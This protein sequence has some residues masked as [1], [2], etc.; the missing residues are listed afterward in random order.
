MEST[1]SLS[2][3]DA[4]VES[5]KQKKRKYLLL[6]G[7][8]IIFISIFVSLALASVLS[9]V[10]SNPIYYTFLKIITVLS[11][12]LIAI[13][14]LAIPVLRETGTRGVLGELDKIAPG[15]G[16]DTL[17]ALYL[18]NN[19]IQN[20]RILG[21]S[22]ILALAHIDNTTNKLGALDHTVLFPIS[23][24]KRYLI[25]LI[26]GAIFALIVLIFFP[27][28][29]TSY[30]LS[31]NV[32]P[33]NAG[34]H[35]ELGDIEI[36][37]K[38]PEYTKLSTQKIKGSG[39]EVKAIKGTEV[40]FEAKPL[41]YFEK[42]S[43]IVENGVSV[44]VSK[45]GGKIKAGFTV[46]GSASFIIKETSKALISETFEIKTEEDTE[47]GVSI[48]SPSGETIELGSEEKIDIFFEAQDDYGISKL[49]LTWEN[50]RGQSETPISKEEKET[51]AISD[52]LSWGPG[53]INPGDGDTIKLRVIAYDNDTV[54]G[55]KVGISNAIT[56]ILKDARS[57]HKETLIYAEQL[58]EELI[59]ILGDEIN[60]S[61]DGASAKST[62]SAGNSK[63]GPKIID[64]GEVLKIQKKLTQKIEHAIQT[65]DITIAN[66]KEDEYS[67]FTYF[68]GLSNVELRTKTLLDER[69]YLIESF[70][71]LDIGRLDRLMKR[72]IYE[73][74][75]D[76]LFLDSMLKGD[77][78]VD[79]LR[80]S[81]DLLKEY[82][83]LSELLKQLN[84]SSDEELNAQIQEKL[85]QIK[86]L[87]SQ[88]A[89]K[90]SG[91]NGD[92]KEGFLNQ[93]AFE[94]TDLQAQLDQISKLAREGNIDQALEML[95]SLTQSLQNMM[96]SL[97]NG[98][99]SFGSSM[100]AKEISKLN[101]LISRIEDLEREETSL[102]EN[103]GELKKAL[104]ENPDSP[105]DNLREFIENEKKKVQELISNITEDR[106]KIA[107]DSPGETA[108]E[109]AYLIEKMIEKTE[110]LNNWLQAMNFEEASE[111]ARSIEE[112]IK[113][114]NEMSSLNIGNLGKASGE[115]GSA[116]RLAREIRKDL[117]HFDIEGNS[118]KQFGGIAS[119]QDEIKGQTGDLS[120]EV[121][122]PGDGSFV[123]PEIGEKLGQAEDFMGN[124]S[125]DLRGQQ[126]SKAISNQDEALKALQE[127]KQ[128]AQ[129]MLGQ[130]QLS[131]R[132]NGSPVPMMLGRQSGQ[133][134]QG[135]D[136][137]YVEI[138]AVDESQIGKEFKQ[139][140]LEAM[141]GGSP[142]GFTE[143]NKK[144]YDRIIK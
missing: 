116:N 89:K 117:E 136:N 70:A 34:P 82:E 143:L 54:S 21:T 3:L 135:A 53:G 40:I 33:L 49:M 64:I 52:K 127:A 138:P 77:E 94:V 50:E 134:M 72:E 7:L 68:V 137:R 55:P 62:E 58:M 35:L 101:E 100:M 44:P 121:G 132:G 67:D 120:S 43:L 71:K 109:G 112:S 18:K 114:L 37:L 110:Q 25:P 59:D 92:I 4:L 113:G 103:T 46:L 22:K 87:M 32:T 76:I 75:D 28:N 9:L 29:F 123:S 27:G 118:G 139:R 140:I 79:S 80:S 24:L 144:Y 6:K 141:K 16:E 69:K 93:D 124:A 2:R 142:E 36:T 5:L 105:R 47:P 115:I 26:G 45:S 133:G 102:K 78:L 88:L 19:N 128:Q 48:S 129:D 90:M 20:S 104:L 106:T 15:L 126:V 86:D 108:P 57:K 125:Q 81:K 97:E 61:N 130:M 85:S 119:R 66:M 95:S 91:L 39:G 13:R 63:A 17:N 111:N 96:A 60:I 1:D 98:M 51:S 23:N 56:I 131:A 30:L 10:Y 122:E 74:E 107:S 84:D 99:Q 11:L 83:E 14:A 41:N 42:G 31:F 65:L 73:F 12:I 8:S 38:Y